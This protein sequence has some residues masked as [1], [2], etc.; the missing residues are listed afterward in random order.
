MRRMLMLLIW[1]A[2]AFWGPK[3]AF[4]AGVGK[5]AGTQVMTWLLPASFLLFAS[6]TAYQSRD[7]SL[8]SAAIFM[9]LGLWLLGGIAIL[10]SATLQG[11]GY[12]TDTLGQALVVTL[13]SF[14]PIYT[15]ILAT[16]DGTL[17]ALLLTLIVAPLI[18]V[19]LE[20]RHWILSPQIRSLFSRSSSG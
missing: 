11:A 16:Y 6:I 3:L 9:C 12:R 2:L 15:A 14:I 13:L 10:A 8:P 19:V 1:G 4:E 18:H 7:R 17:Y 20:R 5:H